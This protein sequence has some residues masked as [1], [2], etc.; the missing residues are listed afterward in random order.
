MS[1][2]EEMSRLGVKAGIV[3]YLLF[4]YVEK[5]V[6]GNQLSW[7]NMFTLKYN[8]DVY[9]RGGGTTGNPMENPKVKVS[10]LGGYGP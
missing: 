1:K 8:I 6:E 4:E 5:K 9:S 3:L 10:S 7:T 2:K